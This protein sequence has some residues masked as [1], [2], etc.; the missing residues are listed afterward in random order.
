MYK[1]QRSNTS[2]DEW[3][4]MD[5]KYI[6]ERGVFTDIKILLMTVPAVLMRRGAC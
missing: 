6:R 1:R 4:D 3:M 2:F 5:M